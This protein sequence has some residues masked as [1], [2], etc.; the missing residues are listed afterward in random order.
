MSEWTHTEDSVTHSLLI[1][2]SL[3]RKQREFGVDLREEIYNT[4]MVALEYISGS[5]HRQFNIIRA[6]YDDLLDGHEAYQLLLIDE[7]SI[8][9]AL[10]GLLEVSE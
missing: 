8:D 2:K 1:S 5:N 9:E 10:I 7:D 3:D 6:F 4:E